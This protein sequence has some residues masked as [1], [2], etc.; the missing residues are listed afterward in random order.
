MT[1]KIFKTE[2]E[3]K[4][5]LNDEEYEVCRMKGTERAFTGMYLSLIHI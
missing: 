5:E 3:W 1:D 4:K 2:E